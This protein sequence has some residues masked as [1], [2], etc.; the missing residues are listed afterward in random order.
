MS[1]T[2]DQWELIISIEDRDGEKRK[3]LLFFSPG[4]HYRK[5]HELELNSFYLAETQVPGR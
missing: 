3:S 1:A 2:V 4:H 5:P